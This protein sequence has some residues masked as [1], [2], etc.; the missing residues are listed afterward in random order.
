MRLS[1][2]IRRRTKRTI[3]ILPLCLVCAGMNGVCGGVNRTV[4]WT[5]PCLAARCRC[6]FRMKSACIANRKRYTL[7]H[8]ESTSAH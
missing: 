1:A 6:L 3:E 7:S 2:V 8:I 4:L 5:Y